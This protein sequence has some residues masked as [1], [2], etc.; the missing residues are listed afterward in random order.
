MGVMY[1][2]CDKQGEAFIVDSLRGK[3]KGKN[4]IKVSY[5]DNVPRT[6]QPSIAWCQ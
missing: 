5:C 6:H 4:I 1:H 2:V 3:N